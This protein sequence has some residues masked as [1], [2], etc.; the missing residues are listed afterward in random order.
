MARGSYRIPEY[1]PF[2]GEMM[3][4]IKQTTMGVQDRERTARIQR[5][6]NDLAT[7]AW[8]GDPSAMQALSQ[9]DPELAM[10][11]EDQRLEREAQAEQQR[12]RGVTEQREAAGERRAVAG[13]ES[14]IAK[15]ARDIGA[16]EADVATAEE[17]RF[18]DD[19]T[20]VT[21]EI[22]QFPNY[23]AAQHYGQQQ[24]DQMSRQYP[25][26]W[27]QQGLPLQFDEQ[28]FN[29]IKTAAGPQDL[30]PTRAT[31][32]IDEIDPVT[33]E[34]KQ[35]LVYSDD[36]SPVLDPSGEPVVY[37]AKPTTKK[38]P[39][40]DEKKSA[41]FLHRMYSAQVELENVALRFPDFDPASA[42]EIAKGKSYATM[43]DAFRAYKQAAMDWVR[44]KLRKESGAVIGDVEA[45]DEYDVYFPEP[46][47]PPEM[48]AQKAR[49]RKTAED[50]MM[51]SSSRA[52]TD[53]EP[54]ESVYNPIDAN[55][56]TEAPPKGTFIRL[57]SG[58]VKEVGV[59]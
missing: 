39:S 46:L 10:K 9:A 26:L 34:P 2:F 43:T 5:E 36:G 12:M 25:E 6:K 13:E 8:M 45:E 23:D 40:G 44:A 37:G 18:E 16:A 53:P 27:K 31:Q 47:D 1:K 49:A 15:E 54:G 14:R 33:K 42:W 59:K 4:G 38:E 21:T 51:M 17:E 3:R 41:G 28:S 29:D 7:K 20:R 57:P 19:M 58:L 22:A 24:T 56:L 35:S 50:A 11:V 30:P 52:W 32:I 55:T 48:L